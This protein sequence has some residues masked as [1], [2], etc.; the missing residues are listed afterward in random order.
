MSRPVCKWLHHQL[1]QWTN[2]NCFLCYQ[3]HRDLKLYFVTLC[4]SCHATE[5]MLKKCLVIVPWETSPDKWETPHRNTTQK[6][7]HMPPEWRQAKR[8]AE[9][10]SYVVMQVKT[11]VSYHFTPTRRAILHICVYIYV[12]LY[13]CVYL[14]TRIHT[15][16]HTAM[17]GL[18]TGYI[19]RNTSSG[20]LVIVQTSGWTYTNIDGTAYYTSRL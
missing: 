20:D 11:T 14:Y 13:V 19:I 15:H 17:Y 16:T 6:G 7:R 5:V 9:I 4:C 18:M 12:Y 10:K 1:L 2:L 8:K 3:L